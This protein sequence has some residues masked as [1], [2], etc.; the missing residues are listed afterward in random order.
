MFDK[1]KYWERRKQGKRGQ[2]DE[3]PIK[4]TEGLPISDRKYRRSQRIVTR[5]E[6]IPKPTRK[7]G[8]LSRA[9]RNRQRNYT[10]V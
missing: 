1:K 6:K 7:G 4:I 10:S 8:G 9:R 5:V 3:I 2:D